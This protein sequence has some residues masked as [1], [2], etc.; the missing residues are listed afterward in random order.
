MLAG[1]SL[2]SLS[3]HGTFWNSLQ[4]LAW[5]NK[6]HALGQTLIFF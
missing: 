4:E 2:P 3:G 1:M 5:G 6:S